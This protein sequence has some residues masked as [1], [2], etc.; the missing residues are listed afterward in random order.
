MLPVVWLDSA[1]ANLTEI[2]TFIAEE[3]PVASKPVVTGRSAPGTRVAGDR[4][5]TSQTA[6]MGES[7]MQ[8]RMTLTALTAS[9]L[10]T[11]AL[12]VTPEAVTE[13]EFR[14]NT[15][16]KSCRLDIKTDAGRKV[17]IRAEQSDDFWSVTLSSTMK[18]ETMAPYYDD[19]GLYETFNFEVTVRSMYVGEQE[20]PITQSL[21]LSPMLSKLED[22][23]PLYLTV[24]GNHNVA[25]IARNLST[26]EIKVENLFALTGLS[27]GVSAF[28]GCVQRHVGDAPST[29]STEALL[30]DTR[31]RFNQEFGYWVQ[32]YAHAAKCNAVT[33]QQSKVDQYIDRA[34]DAFYPGILNIYKRYQYKD[35]LK[36]K[37]SHNKTLGELS[38]LGAGVL[39]GVCREA[40]LLQN[41][42]EG[43]L[44]THLKIAEEVLN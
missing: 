18:A 4:P 9:L 43:S 24:E 41:A 1:I 10:S 33:Y 37:A 23:S 29:S 22:N 3:N 26:G 39:R 42:L 8:K 28:Q 14:E 12:A 38:A 32:N 2:I 35:N 7:L 31:L 17:G 27:D 34:G 25:A 44:Q 15:E 40:P 13:S 6:T 11:S 5:H 19:M 20:V 30:F 16:N 36:D 21:W